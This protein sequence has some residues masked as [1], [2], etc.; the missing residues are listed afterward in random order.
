MAA[1]STTVK[2]DLLTDVTNDINDTSDMKL[3]LKIVNVDFTPKMTA[4]DYFYNSPKHNKYSILLPKKFNTK[5]LKNNKFK[6][7]INIQSFLSKYEYIEV[8]NLENVN[9]TL[10]INGIN[11]VTFKNKLYFN[12]IK[13]PFFK[14]VMKNPQNYEFLL[15]FNGA[16]DL[17]HKININYYDNNN[18]INPYTFYPYNTHQ[19]HF[20]F[21]TESISFSC[22]SD[23]G[24][25]ILNINNI[26]VIKI[27]SKQ[28]LQ[29]IYFSDCLFNDGFQNI[30]L[31]ETIN[32]NTI[33]FSRVR[34]CNIITINC[35]LVDLYQY[36][37]VTF[38]Y[39]DENIK[40]SFV[41]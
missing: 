13:H 34:L 11:I 39:N 37:Y 7:S 15:H 21:A 24:Y 33:N 25:I 27:K 40:E 18:N 16:K 20:N 38:D 41:E 22:D 26:N 12:N 36:R 30:F 2:F 4:N 5:D 3:N 10:N 32:K 9:I 14:E 8:C 29:R 31:N 23:D 6:G 35:S 28:Q 1:D 19:M 17:P